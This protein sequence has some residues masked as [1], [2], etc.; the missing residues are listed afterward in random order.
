MY[1]KDDAQ[2][3]QLPPELVSHVTSYLGESTSQEDSNQ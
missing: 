1:L 3:R 2:D